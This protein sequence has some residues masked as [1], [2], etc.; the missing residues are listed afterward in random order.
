MGLVGTSSLDDDDPRL[1][2]GRFLYVSSGFVVFSDR[3]MIRVLAGG[4]PA[5][6]CLLLNCENLECGSIMGV[7]KSL[8]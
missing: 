7:A 4:G 3:S 8:W 2:V 5:L 6:V 1:G